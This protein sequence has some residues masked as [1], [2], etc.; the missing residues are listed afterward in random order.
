MEDPVKKVVSFI[1]TENCFEVMGQLRRLGV[2]TGADIRK[3]MSMSRSEW[4]TFMTE[5]AGIAGCGTE[6]GNCQDEE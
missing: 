3:A 4:V 6:C 2:L 1:T 5:K